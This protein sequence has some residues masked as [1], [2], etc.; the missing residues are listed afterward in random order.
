MIEIEEARGKKRK[1]KKA[2]FEPVPE[3]APEPTEGAPEASRPPTEQPARL[4]PDIDFSGGKTL[5]EMNRELYELP[6]GPVYYSASEIEV[7]SR[8]R[9]RKGPSERSGLPGGP[10]APAPR[11]G[12]ASSPA[13]RQEEPAFEQRRKKGRGQEEPQLPV[14]APAGGEIQ[15]QLSPEEMGSTGLPQGFTRDAFGNVV[16]Q[17]G[18]APE[19]APA[20]A[21]AI[22]IQEHVRTKKGQRRQRRQQEAAGAEEPAGPAPRPGERDPAPAQKRP[23]AL[24]LHVFF[25]LLHGM[26]GDVH[27]LDGPEN[28]P[29]IDPS[30]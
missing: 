27:N 1:A 25:R 14:V 30:P 12:A 3:T 21:S 16:R 7:E 8:A 23:E 13:A 26:G 5:L 2:A 22:T 24:P 18:T 10:G 9:K 15:L 4:Q 11:G 20:G 19:T 29:G 17:G 6:K 28:P